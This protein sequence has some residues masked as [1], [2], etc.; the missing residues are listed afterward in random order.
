MKKAT[1]L[2]PRNAAREILS[3]S[4]AERMLSSGSWV[5]A[6]IPKSVTPNAKRQRKFKR[7]RAEAGFK[8]LEVLLAAQVFNSL[9]ARLQKGESLAALIKRLLELP[10]NAD[11]KGR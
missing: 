3:D 7:Q 9:Q 4:D 1:L 5:I 10:D 6:K 11:E 8:R 2:A